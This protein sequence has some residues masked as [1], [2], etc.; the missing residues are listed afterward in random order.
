MAD[1]HELHRG[2]DN[3]VAESFGRLSG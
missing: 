2:Q 1:D 3:R